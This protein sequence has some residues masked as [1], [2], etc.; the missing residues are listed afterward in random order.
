MQNEIISEE[1]DNTQIEPLMTE[2]VA[3]MEQEPYEPV[4]LFRI[5]ENMP[6]ELKQQLAKFNKQTQNMNQILSSSNSEVE[7]LNDFSSEDN[8]N[9]DYDAD[10]DTVD[11]D[12]SIIEE[13][14]ISVEEIG[15]LF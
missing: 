8:S 14:S 3:P 9:D 1:S 7:E 12:D 11:N 2:D 6:E 15:D 13:D 10:D 4:G 5:D